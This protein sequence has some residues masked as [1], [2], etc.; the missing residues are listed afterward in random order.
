[1]SF[2]REEVAEI[3]VATFNRAADAD[4]LDYWVNNSGF[5]NI[6][7]VASSL[8]DSKEAKE[9]YPDGTS[10][11]QIVESA[12]QNLFGRE[13]DSAGLDY[14]VEQ[15]DSGAF[16]QSLM[17]LAMING[18]QNT[19]EFGNDAT[20]MQ[21]KTKVGLEFADS[22]FNDVE[23]AKDVMKNVTDDTNTI[24]DAHS[25]IRNL[26][27]EDTFKF[28]QD[29]ISGRTLYNIYDENNDGI[30]DDEISLT[31]NTDGTFN[32]NVLSGEDKGTLV[33]GT[34]SIDDNGILTQIDDE[35]TSYITAIE[36]STLDNTLVINWSD[37]YK[38]TIS[39]NNLGHEYFML[40]EASADVFMA[41]TGYIKSV[42]EEVALVGQTTD[43]STSA[44]GI[45]IA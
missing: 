3:Y 5:D 24:N 38:N 16:S 18:A 22:D 9:M 15:L 12:Y 27:V 41:S 4:G 8:F 10:N 45:A 1:M 37:T 20:Y 39:L 29:W 43:I 13:A 14:W 17:L 42:E 26:P 31:Y 40:D 36:S 44:V 33:N 34:Y 32:A 7:D 19:E 6:E 28:T 21:N 2:T 35:G 30:Y 23:K 11:T 25:M